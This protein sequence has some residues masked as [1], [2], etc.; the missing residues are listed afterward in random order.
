MFPQGGSQDFVGEGPVLY[1]RAL[2]LRNVHGGAMSLINRVMKNMP[3]EFVRFKVWQTIW[4]H[5][6]NPS[7]SI[8][9]YDYDLGLRV[10]DIDLTE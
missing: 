2:R 9:G 10:R 5:Y 6:S 3:M 8:A 1:Y 7:V 4:H